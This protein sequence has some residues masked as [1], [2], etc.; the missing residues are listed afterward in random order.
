MAELKI[1]SKSEQTTATYSKDGYRAEIT[2]N[3]NASDKSIKD[4]NMSLYGEGSGS[5]LGNVNAGNNGSGELT[6]S[7]NGVAQS[8]LSEVCALVEEVHTAIEA[9]VAGESASSDAE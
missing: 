2:Y 5:Y 9:S 8:K 6:Y 7:L 1:N 4:I 3:V